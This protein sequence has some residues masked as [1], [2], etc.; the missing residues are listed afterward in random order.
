MLYEDGGEVVLVGGGRTLKCTNTSLGGHVLK[1]RQV[2]TEVSTRTCFISLK[3]LSENE[4]TF[5]F[6]SRTLETHG[7][8]LGDDLALSTDWEEDDIT[9][10]IR[11]WLTRF[12]TAET[13]LWFIG[14]ADEPL[15]ETSVKLD[16]DED[17][18]SENG[19]VKVP[20]QKIK[21]YKKF[22]LQTTV[23]VHFTTG[24]LDVGQGEHFFL[25]GHVKDGALH[26][27]VRRFG[28]R[29]REGCGGKM[30]PGLGLLCHYRSGRPSGVCW[31]QLVGGPWL[32]GEVD[33]N[34]EF[35]DKVDN[36][37]W[38]YPLLR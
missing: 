14:V 5:L 12:S 11:T 27:F 38:F 31:Q 29:F 32:Y 15:E 7:E 30:F 20:L 10:T 26:G 33:K 1:C 3:V 24:H 17:V 16:V 22:T 21:D 19:Y 6:N 36:F 23:D 37:S 25:E 34:G 18:S 2:F 9:D 4:E 13:P 35:F 8:T 28:M